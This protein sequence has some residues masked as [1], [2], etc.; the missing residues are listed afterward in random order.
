MKYNKASLDTAIFKIHP[1]FVDMENQ[2][3]ELPSL[4]CIAMD[5]AEMCFLG[6]IDRIKNGTQYADVIKHAMLDYRAKGF[7]TYGDVDVNTLLTD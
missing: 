1:M 2:G 3:L 5:T 7:V 4:E 6:D